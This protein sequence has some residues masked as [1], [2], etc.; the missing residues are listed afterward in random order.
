MNTI[1]KRITLIGF[2][3]GLLMMAVSSAN[4]AFTVNTTADTQDFPAGDGI[5]AD[6]FGNC[7]LRAA[8]TESNALAG[9]DIIILPAGTY[10][11]TLTVASENLNAGGDWDITTPITING[12]GSGTTILQANALP[13]VATERVLHCITAATA[14]VV[15][16]VTIQNG[17]YFTGTFGGGLRLETNSTNVTLNRVIV[18]NNRTAGSGGGIHFAT[19][20]TTLTVNNSTISDN[21]ALG[22]NGGGINS[23]VNH[24]LNIN[25]SVLTGNASTSTSTLSTTGGA[26]TSGGSGGTSIISITGGTI[27]NNSATNTSTGAGYGGAI[28]SR[29]TNLTVTGVTLSNNS[30][31][32]SGGAIT[33][34]LGAITGRTT[35]ITGSTISNNTANT[36]PAEAGS[37]GITFD[38]FSASSIGTLNIVNSALFGNT[39]PAT[40]KGGAIFSWV[41]P[42]LAGSNTV[43][44]TNSVIRGNSAQIGGGINNE[45]AGIGAGD[46]SLINSTVSDNTSAE[47]GGGIHNLCS[48]T[49]SA[50]VNLTNSTVSGNTVPT[51]TRDGGGIFNGGF[52]ASTNALNSTISGNSA[53]NGGGIAHESTGSVDL[54]FVTVAFNSATTNAGGGLLQ[55]L[56]G[57]G[58]IN[59]KNTIV[60]KNTSFGI[61]PDIC[62]TI[63]SQDY[64]HVEIV[65]TPAVL[66][67]LSANDVT[68][69]DPLL[70]LL[71]LNGI[72]VTTKSHLPMPSSP[73][74]NTIPN[75]TNGCGTPSITTSQNGVPRPTAL[76][77]EKGAV[78]IPLAPTAADASI[79]GRILTPFGR[80]LTNATVVLTNSNTGEIR[81]ARSAS[82]GYFNFQDLQTG[83]FYILNVNSKRYTFNPQ[84]FTLNENIDDL[85]LTPQ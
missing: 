35:T 45:S 70:G 26:V 23:T 41:E 27:S 47:D 28:F 59:I 37:G 76:G 3:F 67:P 9:A 31:N 40:G 5:C 20:G 63:T 25:N 13:G 33:C 73:V 24:T 77:C 80:G 62:G 69:T 50:N 38:N 71:A 52:L 56:A 79:R 48:S 54:N 60:A 64:N 55:G 66:L 57:A 68:G 58:P 11:Q 18:T 2:T 21:K 36:N 12:A 72:G 8:I 83:D 10:T 17:N 43:N 22:G 42:G 81:M 84:S 29:D 16:D 44:V 30:T 65:A 46:I 4:A 19:A 78:E 32:G 49:G 85:I 6:P 61:C 53:S 15:N 14:V 1:I 82:F 39:A 34:W 7:S 51:A 75:G 74:V